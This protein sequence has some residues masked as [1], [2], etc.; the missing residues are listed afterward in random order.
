LEE[1]SVLKDEFYSIPPKQHHANTDDFS[2]FDSDPRVILAHLRTR[3]QQCESHQSEEYFVHPLLVLKKEKCYASLE[4]SELRV[5]LPLAW[6]SDL[7]KKEGGHDFSIDVTLGLSVEKE[8]LFATVTETEN[9]D[10]D[11]ECL[12]WVIRWLRD[13]LTNK[14]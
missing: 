14:A 4:G 8:E 5:S 6:H 7:G 3:L 12:E 11:G 9:A 1:F 10:L 13:T 2:L